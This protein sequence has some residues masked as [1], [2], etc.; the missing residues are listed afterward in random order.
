MHITWKS[1]GYSFFNR[2]PSA[3]MYLAPSVNNKHKFSRATPRKRTA[4]SISRVMKLLFTDCERVVQMNSN[5]FSGAIYLPTKLF[6]NSL[7]F[8]SLSSTSINIFWSFKSFNR[9]ASSANFSLFERHF[10]SEG[11]GLP[12]SLSKDDRWLFLNLYNGMSAQRNAL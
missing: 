4:L 5:V 12:S 3:V 2:T 8:L 1:L 7:P 6:K 11:N 9:N 10:P